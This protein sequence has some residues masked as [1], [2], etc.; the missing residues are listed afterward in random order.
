MS[1]VRSMTFTFTFD[2]S[3]RNCA[4]DNS[5][6]QTTVSAPDETTAWRSSTTFPDPI[7]VDGSGRSRR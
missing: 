7:K 5:P 4:G 2:S 1:A 6:S 3:D